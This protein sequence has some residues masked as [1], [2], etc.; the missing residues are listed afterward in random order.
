MFV[1]VATPCRI[2]CSGASMSGKTVFTFK[3]ID[4]I[5]RIFSPAPKKII[6]F[7]GA[8]QPLFEEY[9]HKVTF[10]EGL[11]SLD[12]IGSTDGGVFMVIDDLFLQVGEEMANFFTKYSHHSGISLCFI[13]QQFFYQNKYSRTISLNAD[14]IVLFKSVRDLMSISYLSR[15]MYPKK[16]SF[17]VDCYRKATVAPYSY[18]FINLQPLYPEILRIQTNIFDLHPTI[19]APAAEDFKSWRRNL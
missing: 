17:L 5:D 11:P 1:P 18:I 10:I 9:I 14:I 6:Y 4:N 7:Y 8:W 19:L 2:I 12:K 3:L 16:N 13:T 15:Q